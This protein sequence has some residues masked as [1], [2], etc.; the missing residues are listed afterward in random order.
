VGCKLSVVTLEN[1]ALSDNFLKVELAANRPVNSMIDVE[2][3]GLTQQ[4][5]RER[6]PFV[7]L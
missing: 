4:G 7:V 3:G 2:I 6:S 1:G 5:L